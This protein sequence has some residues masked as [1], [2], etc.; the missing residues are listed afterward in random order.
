MANVIN[1]TTIHMTDFIQ[2]RPGQFRAI[3][4][5]KAGFFTVVD[6]IGIQS[7]WKTGARWKRGIDVFRSFQKGALQTIEFKAEESNN[8]LTV[9]ARAGKTVKLMD[10]ELFED[11]EVG[12]I[13]QIWTNTNL[14][15]QKQ[16]T[17][18]AAKT[19]ASKAFVKNA[20]TESVAA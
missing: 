13:N 2:D 12:D 11:M 18:V 20:S 8:W 14:Y 17:A 3:V 16:Y 7:N 5:V 19:W 10:R 6:D 9:F 4:K 15:D 1:T